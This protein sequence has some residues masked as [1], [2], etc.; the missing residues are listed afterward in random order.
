MYGKEGEDA[1]AYKAAAS[2]FFNF[3]QYL[4]Y[5]NYSNILLTL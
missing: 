2:Y 5:F 1:A 4:S 3:K